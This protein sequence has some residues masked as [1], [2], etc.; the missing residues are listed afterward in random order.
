MAEAP[1]SE[2]ELDAYRSGAD[3][4]LAELDE[5]YYLHYAG[6]KPDFELARSTSGTPT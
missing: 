3:R 4:F 2:R 1:F 6:H 5:E